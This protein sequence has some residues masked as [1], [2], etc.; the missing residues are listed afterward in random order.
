MKTTFGE[1]SHGGLHDLLATI[2]SGFD[3][4]VCHEAGT[5]NERSFIVKSSA[6]FLGS[7]GCQPVAFGSLP[8]AFLFRSVVWQCGFAASYRELQAGGLVLSRSFSAL[9]ITA[10]V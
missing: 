8:N 9:P 4:N 7:T 2:L 10:R 1:A 6:P 5:M 3:L